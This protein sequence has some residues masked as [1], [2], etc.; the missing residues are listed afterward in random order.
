MIVYFFVHGIRRIHYA[1]F[2]YSLMSVQLMDLGFSFKAGF[3]NLELCVS[4]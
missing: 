1:A 3:D 4:L 2:D